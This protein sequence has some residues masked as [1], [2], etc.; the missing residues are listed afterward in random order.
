MRH[1]C[2]HIHDRAYRP[3]DTVKCYNQRQVTRK[4]DRQTGLSN[5][6]YELGQVVRVTIAGADVTVVN[7]SL[8]CDKAST[9]WCECN[10]A[11]E[12]QQEK[13]PNGK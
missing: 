4:R 12:E 2:R 13:K 9:P 7:I 10:G 6:S 8:M 3:R 11:P 1:L 5:V